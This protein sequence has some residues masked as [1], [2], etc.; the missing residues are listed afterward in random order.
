MAGG[1]PKQWF[2]AKIMSC[3]K[4]RMIKPKK[5]SEHKKGELIYGY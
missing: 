3:E 1:L 2:C 4:S 5:E